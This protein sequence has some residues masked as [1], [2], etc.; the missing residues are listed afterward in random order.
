MKSS[1]V[2]FVRINIPTMKICIHAM[3]IEKFSVQI[4]PFMNMQMIHVERILLRRDERERK[5]NPHYRLL[6]LGQANGWYADYGNQCRSYY[7]CTD[8][9][10]SKSDQCP[11][12]SKWNPHRLRCDDPR[13]IAAPCKR[14]I[15][16]FI[17]SFAELFPISGGFR[18]SNHANS[19]IGNDLTLLLTLCLFFLF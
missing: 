14:S 13:Y 4:D 17:H 18:T 16:F 9:R 3:I 12:G 11:W 2:Y 19:F 8:Q 10:K 7:L 1:L 15:I 6:G 5:N